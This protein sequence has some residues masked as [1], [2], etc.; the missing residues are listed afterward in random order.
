MKKVTPSRNRGDL[1][2]AEPRIQ[3]G[4]NFRP[5]RCIYRTSGYEFTW[6]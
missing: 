5:L 6:L 2:G 1:E 3:A 4:E